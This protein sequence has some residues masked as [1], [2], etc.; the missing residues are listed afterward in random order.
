MATLMF[1][2][3]THDGNRDTYRVQE[4]LDD[5]IRGLQ[6]GDK[7]AAFTD[8]GDGQPVWFRVDAIRYL[9]AD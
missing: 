7:F 5:V 6:G 4:D 9:Y 1:F 3:P 8:P 2:G